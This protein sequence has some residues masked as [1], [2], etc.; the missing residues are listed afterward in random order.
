MLAKRP[1]EQ[2]KNYSV[3]HSNRGTL[4]LSLHLARGC[5]W[6]SFSS[7][8]S[9]F[10]CYLYATGLSVAFL[11]VT[12]ALQADRVPISIRAVVTSQ[13][14]A[15]GTNG[16]F[17]SFLLPP[18][19]DS[20]GHVAFQ[21]TG[22]GIKGIWKEESS[23]LRQVVLV[24]DPAV[25]TGGDVFASIEDPVLSKA[26][27][28]GFVGHLRDAPLERRAGLW[29]ENPDG[30]LR[31]VARQGEP[32]PV[33]EQEP[34]PRL[35]DNSL[36]QNFGG[37][38]PFVLQS[39]GDAAFVSGLELPSGAL[40]GR[41]LFA[42]SNAQLEVAEITAYPGEQSDIRNISLN[43]VFSD[44]GLVSTPL[45][46]SAQAGSGQRLPGG[47]TTFQE[48]PG[49]E[50]AIFSSFNRP[51]L[52]SAGELIFPVRLANPSGMNVG[53]NPLNDQG[54]FTT[55]GGL[56]LVARENDPAPGTGFAIHSFEAQTY[57]ADNGVALLAT[58]LRNAPADQRFAYFSRD[59]KVE[60][61]LRLVY[62]TGSQVPDTPT[63]TVFVANNVLSFGR[64]YAINGN[65]NI[66]FVAQ[67]Q[68][69]SGPSYLGLFAKVGNELALL[70]REGDAITL[71]PGDTRII[72]G[73]INELAFDFQGGTGNGDGRPSGINDLDQI[74]VR[75]S[76]ADRS[77][78]MVVIDDITRPLG[79]R[80]AEPTIQLDPSGHP[81]LSYHVIPGLEY[82][83]ERSFDLA[84]PG[85]G[86]SLVEEP[87][88]FRS[89]GKVTFTDNS[90]DFDDPGG[91][92]PSA[93]F[94][95][96]LLEDAP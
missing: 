8:V 47:P 95:R 6:C 53:V 36:A 37:I 21:A 51:D 89:A 54:V 58:R 9:S 85:G 32:A 79:L 61:P 42:E 49:T 82:S 22:G 88:C 92:I 91:T 31:L 71:A 20:D 33:E 87:D 25:G 52:N 76:F 11:L 1:R 35:F 50:G 16:E 18:Q 41:G 86:W 17:D 70:L 38:H 2:A 28:I 24:G 78:A 34:E 48:A 90:I 23:G 65:G 4:A 7:V 39:D 68:D 19:I 13:D 43:P 94:Y 15:P 62:Q 83:I 74:A 56:S 55:A 73:G 40:A 57:L 77:F 14:S 27:L 5:D 10:S 64:V 69:P 60:D 29:V 75:L 72:Q 80:N 46:L 84:N 81:A 67:V 3:S 26:G 96:V 44:T 63:G 12:C 45:T 93:V 59:L 30:S 66:V